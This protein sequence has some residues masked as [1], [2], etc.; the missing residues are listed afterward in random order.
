MYENNLN[1]IVNIIINLK[2]KSISISNA[3]LSAINLM[4]ITNTSIV[5]RIIS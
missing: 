3:I 4:I 2:A 5:I 1:E